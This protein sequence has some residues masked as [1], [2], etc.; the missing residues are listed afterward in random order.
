M[1]NEIQTPIDALFQFIEKYSPVK[2]SKIPRSFKK[3]KIFDNYI[4]ILEANGMIEVKMPIFSTERVFVF[5]SKKRSFD[6]NIW[7]FEEVKSI[8]S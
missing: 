6:S 7:T 2:E 1:N 4:R 5:K 8:I 3:L